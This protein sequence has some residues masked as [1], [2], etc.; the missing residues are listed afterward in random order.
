MPHRGPRGCSVHWEDDNCSPG[1]LKKPSTA[2]EEEKGTRP[3]PLVK[4]VFQVDS[5]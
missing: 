4:S 5:F 1:G 3:C 2:F